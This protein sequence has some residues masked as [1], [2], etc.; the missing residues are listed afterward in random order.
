MSHIEQLH[1]NSPFF[2][3]LCW[4]TDVLLT[5]GG[6]EILGTI[7]SLSVHVLHVVGRTILSITQKYLQVILCQEAVPGA[8][9]GSFLFQ[10]F[11]EQGL[12]PPNPRSKEFGLFI[13]ELLKYRVLD[14]ASFVFEKGSSL[15]SQPQRNLMLATVQKLVGAT[16]HNHNHH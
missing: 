13:K 11:C 15:K 5:P 2:A 10:T 8:D 12:K 4:K 7:P 14:I 16:I 3:E 1:I 6:L 9:R